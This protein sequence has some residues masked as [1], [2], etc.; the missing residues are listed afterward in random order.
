MTNNDLTFTT[1]GSGVM[2]CAIMGGIMASLIELRSGKEIPQDDTPSHLPGKFIA[3]DMR[4]EAETQVQNALGHYKLPLTTLTNENLRGTKEA[5]IILLACKPWAFKDVL[6]AEGMKEALAGKLLISILA[7][8]TAEQIEEFLYD[9]DASAQ[10]K[11]HIVKVMPNTASMV[12]ESTTVIAA[13]NPPLPETQL[14]LATWIFSRIGRVAHLPA[15]V[16]DAATALV[17]SGPAFVAVMLEAMADGAVA[18]GIPRAEAQMMAAQTMRGTAALVL[19]GEHPAILK[20]KVCTPGGCT[21]GGIMAME[22]AGVRGG[23]SRAIREA[24]M[25]SSKLGQGV[26]GSNVNGTWR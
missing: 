16:M 7:G 10:Y 21:I 14:T 3:C 20:D 25:V 15:S 23:V 9:N 2:G 24:T 18:M 17:G 26:A 19:N 11:C 1:L 5:D 8:V 22:E 12:R 4:K 13:R 6:G